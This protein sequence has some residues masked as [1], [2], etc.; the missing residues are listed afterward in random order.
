MLKG[1]R[2]FIARGNMVE[3]AVAFVMGSAVTAIVTS[4]V[5]SVINPLIAAIFSMP[6]MDKVWN[7]TVNGSVVRFGAFVGA[8]INFLIIALVVYFCIVVPMNKLAEMSSRKKE[9]G[10]GELSDEEKQTQL[11]AEIKSLLSAQ[12]QSTS[13]AG[14]AA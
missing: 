14:Q 7:V 4:L 9:E 6:D 12:G 8:I 5:D 3:M 1:F 2:D 10:K 11:L 13:G